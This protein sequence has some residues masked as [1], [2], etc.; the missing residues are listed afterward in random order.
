MAMHNNATTNNRKKP[1]R[2]FITH[3]RGYEFALASVRRP[4]VV[5]RLQVR[6]VGGSYFG[7]TAMK[8]DMNDCPYASARERDIGYVTK[9][10]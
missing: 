6:K 3:P 8:I 10:T 4:S 1:R 5:P 2:V 7:N 9:V